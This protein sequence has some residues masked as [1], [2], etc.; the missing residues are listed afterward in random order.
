MSFFANRLNSKNARK[1]LQIAAKNPK[2]VLRVLGSQILFAATKHSKNEPGSLRNRLIENFVYFPTEYDHFKHTFQR[3]T[4]L[5]NELIN[6]KVPQVNNA[7]DACVFL[8]RGTSYGHN[9]HNYLVGCILREIGYKVSFIICSGRM[10]RCGL[11][12]YGEFAQPYTC[13]T[14]REILKNFNL[15]GFHKI[16]LNDF[17]SIEEDESIQ[18]IEQLNSKQLIDFE[19]DGISIFKELNKHLIRYYFGD[20]KII[21]KNEIELSS[22]CKSAVRYLFRYKRLIDEIKPSIAVLFNGLFFPESHLLKCSENNG[23]TTILTERGMRKNTLFLSKR[24]PACHYTLNQFW[25]NQ[26]K[27]ISDEYISKAENYLQNRIKAPED[28]A[29]IKRNVT[30]EKEEKYHDLGKYSI[31]FASVIHD[32]ASMVSGYIASTLIEALIILCKIAIKNK[33]NLVIRSH[34]DERNPSNPSAY[35]LISILRENQ[36]LDSQYVTCLDSNEV[37]NPYILAKRAEKVI[38]YNGTLGIEL[39][40]LGIPII[41]LGISHYSK[42]GFTYDAT[43]YDILKRLLIEKKLTISSEMKRLALSYLY[44]YVY[45]ANLP[46]DQ[47]LVEYSPFKYKIPEVSNLGLQ[48]QQTQSIKSRV[49]FLLE[50]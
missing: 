11:N 23:I 19:Y 13:K 38:I 29:G 26:K 2:N 30:T 37:W 22:H 33:H 40:A 39:P 10:E 14:C 25:D 32:T 24:I 8:L 12:R 1:F 34:P 44:Y 4:Q 42:K 9:L 17:F 43:D 48:H 41:N 47:L 31:V 15:N 46:V 35:P 3:G 27:Q 36:L 28:P 5:Y 50:N 6:L 16:F 21:K 20:L 45:E 49:E 18:A 7:K